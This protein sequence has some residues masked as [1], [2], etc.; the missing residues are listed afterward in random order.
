MFSLRKRGKLLLGAFPDIPISRYSNRRCRLRGFGN[1]CSRIPWPRAPWPTRGPDG[2][3]PTLI[4]AEHRQPPHTH[5]R[6]FSGGLE[7][8]PAASRPDVVTP[9][10][11]CTTPRDRQPLPA[12]GYCF[13]TPKTSSPPARTRFHSRLQSFCRQR[14]GWPRL[15]RCRMKLFAPGAFYWELT[16]AQKL[17]QELGCNSSPRALFAQA[18]WARSAGTCGCRMKLFA[19]VALC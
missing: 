10:M 14:S 11:F 16:K 15:A 9:H 5:I 6:R 13:H 18:V 17:I 4:D 12:G 2:P 3:R 7:T 1:K 19:S 8:A